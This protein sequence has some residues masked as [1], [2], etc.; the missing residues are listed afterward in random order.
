MNM[1]DNTLG[2]LSEKEAQMLTSRKLQA[3]HKMLYTEKLDTWGYR[4]YL[5]KLVYSKKN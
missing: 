3:A 5:K 4:L 2:T 1:Y